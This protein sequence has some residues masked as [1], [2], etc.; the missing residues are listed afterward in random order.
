[1]KPYVQGNFILLIRAMQIL[2]NLLPHTV[3]IV[4]ILLLFVEVIDDILVR[5][6]CS[7]ICTRN[8][9]MLLSELLVF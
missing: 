8:Y 2:Q 7:I 3:E 5:K 9:E 1:M 4:I 6:I